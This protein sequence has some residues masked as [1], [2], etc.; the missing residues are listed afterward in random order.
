MGPCPTLIY[1]WFSQD[2]WSCHPWPCRGLGVQGPPCTCFLLSISL[3]ALPGWSLSVGSG[4]P[5][6][7]CSCAPVSHL[8]PPTHLPSVCEINVVFVWV[9][10]AS[11]ALLRH[12]LSRREGKRGRRPQPNASF[13]A[14]FCLICTVSALDRASSWVERKG[15]GLRT[16]ALNIFIERSK[17]LGIWTQVFVQGRGL[18]S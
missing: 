9:S 18:S 7:V 5:M 16:L 17:G 12:I 6:T 3:E 13:L 11:L 8:Y 15:A 14:P 1:L 4:S 2:S 10:A